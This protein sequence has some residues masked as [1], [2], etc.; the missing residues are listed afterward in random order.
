MMMCNYDDDELAFVDATG[1][2]GVAE[3]DPT[4]LQS[5]QLAASCYIS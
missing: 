4:A 5:M 1:D 2:D 3:I